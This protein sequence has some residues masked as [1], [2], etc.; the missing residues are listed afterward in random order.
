M[1]VKLCFC[2][3]PKI[4]YNI[5]GVLCCLNVILGLILLFSELLY[6]FAVSLCFGIP[7]T[8]WL[9]SQI[10][11][12]IIYKRLFAYTFVV[13]MII[14]L[15]GFAILLG[16][17]FSLLVVEGKE[18]FA[19]VLPISLWLVSVAI[20]VYLFSCLMTYVKEEEI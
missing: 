20:A 7:A 5:V 6:G 1:P 19:Y 3:Q 16:I 13:L 10:K 14:L 4:C 9:I 12:A 11:P 2:V 17:V 18:W 8:F 15:T